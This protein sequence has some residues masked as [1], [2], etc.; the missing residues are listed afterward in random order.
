MSEPMIGAFHSESFHDERLNDEKYMARAFKLARRGVGRVSPNPAVG[1]VLVKSGQV[2]GEGYHECFGGSH[3]EV[4]AIEKAGGKTRGAVAYITLEPCITHYTGKKTPSCVNTLVR[5]GVKRAVI[6][7]RDP[8][9]RVN[10]KGI[11]QLESEGISVTEGILVEEGARL[12]KGFA[13]WIITKRPYV[14]LKAARTS[15]NYAAA[16]IDGNWFTS[17]KSRRRLLSN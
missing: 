13:K 2:V 12:I 14:I 4:N 5:A 11:A 10:G 8:N 3:A 7:I 16:N 9:P 15:D 1:C 17:N 6:A